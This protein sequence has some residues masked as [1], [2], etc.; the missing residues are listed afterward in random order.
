MK[1]ETKVMVNSVRI[2]L[3]RHVVIIVVEISLHFR[4]NSPNV[5]I[6]EL[7]YRQH[8]CKSIEIM[9]LYMFLY[10]YASLIFTLRLNFV[11]GEFIDVATLA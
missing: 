5:N 1:S 3:L 10:I 11:K 9:Y 2:F 8:Y 7:R 6:F 4:S